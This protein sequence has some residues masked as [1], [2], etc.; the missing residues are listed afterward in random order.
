ME[1]RGVRNE[2]GGVV[3][4]VDG[5]LGCERGEGEVLLVQVW[6]GATVGAGGEGGAGGGAR[7]GQ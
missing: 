4:W 2:V 3:G 1:V 7:E 5:V 6:V